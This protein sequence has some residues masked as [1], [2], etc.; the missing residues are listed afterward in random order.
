MNSSILYN[1]MGT[2]TSDS[3]LGA[4]L[5]AQVS[6][7]VVYPQGSP[8]GATNQ[9]GVL[10]KLKDVG[11]GDYHLEP[12]SPALDR[13]DPASTNAI[14]YDGVARPQGAARDSGAFEFVP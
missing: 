6:Y 1:S 7:S 8:V 14:D 10:P 2:S 9:T 12:G 3:L 4:S 11:A 13:G 5:C